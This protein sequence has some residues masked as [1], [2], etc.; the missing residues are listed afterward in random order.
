MNLLTVAKGYEGKGIGSRFLN[1]GLIPRI[2]KH[3]A[4]TLALFTNSERNCQFY[5]KNGFT[6]FDERQFEYN[7]KS[8][9]SWY[10]CKYLRP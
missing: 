4:E 6:L 9:G 8:I 5:E 10:Y 7:G 2:K 1:E 3:G